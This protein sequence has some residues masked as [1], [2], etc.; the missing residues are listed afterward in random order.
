MIGLKFNKDN[1]YINIEGTNDK[2][3]CKDIP[4]YLKSNPK[5]KNICRTCGCYLNKNS[6]NGKCNKFL[7]K[8]LH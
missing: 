1:H 5:I 4:N 7:W 3:D 6:T 8:F 2:I